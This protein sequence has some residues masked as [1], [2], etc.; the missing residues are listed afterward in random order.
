MFG[1][2]GWSQGGGVNFGL[3]QRLRDGCGCLAAGLFLSF[4]G[5]FLFFLV[6]LP[7]S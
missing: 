2:I 4:I 6:R 3:A 1:R 7:L 5:A